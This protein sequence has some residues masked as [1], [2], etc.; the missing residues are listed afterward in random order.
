MGDPTH[1]KVIRRRPDRQGGSGIHINEYIEEIS[2][3]L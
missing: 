2:I 3:N 1:D